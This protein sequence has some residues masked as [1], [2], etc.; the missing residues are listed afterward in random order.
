MT[1]FQVIYS[2]SD[3]KDTMKGYEGLMVCGL[4]FLDL[5]AV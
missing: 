1:R 2:G 3:L 5:G 4:G